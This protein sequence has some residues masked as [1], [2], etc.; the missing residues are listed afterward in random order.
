ML[1]FPRTYKRKSVCKICLDKS[2][3][4][5]HS[6]YEVLTYELDL[7]TYILHNQMTEFQVYI[8]ESPMF[9]RDWVLLLIL[10]LI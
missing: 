8:W 5:W 9:P 10:I 4:A 6:S 2:L 3:K 7:S 1:Q